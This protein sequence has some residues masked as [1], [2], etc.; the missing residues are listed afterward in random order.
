MNTRAIEQIKAR[1]N[2]EHDLGADAPI[3]WSVME[4]AELVEV[5]VEHV[6]N[7]E[8]QIKALQERRNENE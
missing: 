2:P 3:H 8:L 1:Y 6:E 4:L 5:L 7:L